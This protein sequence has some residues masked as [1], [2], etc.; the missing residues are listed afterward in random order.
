MSSARQYLLFLSFLLSFG[1]ASYQSGQYAEI[2]SGEH[3]LNTPITGKLESALTTDHYAVVS[4]IFGNESSD[5]LR[6]KKV[7]LNFNDKELNESINIIVGQD[8]ATWSESIKYKVAI[9]Q[10]NKEIIWGSIA[11]A[12]AA[13]A[14]ASSSE[15][16]L[17]Y[18]GTG[19]YA[20]SS[21][22]LVVNEVLDKMEKLERGKLFPRTHLYKPFSVPAAP[23]IRIVST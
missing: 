17:F 16:A 2:I 7:R 21:G 22:V 5:W 19:T 6:I 20:L 13:T 4:F 18:V 23:D 8:I 15:S 12:G 11:L 14:I 1:C 3:P 10:W 9:D